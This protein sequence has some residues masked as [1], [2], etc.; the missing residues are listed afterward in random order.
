MMTCIIKWAM[1]SEH[2]NAF[3]I[4]GPL[5]REPTIITGFSPT[6]LQSFDVFMLTSMRCGTNYPY[7]GDLRRQDAQVMPL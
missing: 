2:G 6:L 4:T 5:C 3:R 1:T 7:A